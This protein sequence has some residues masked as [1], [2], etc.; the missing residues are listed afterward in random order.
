MGVDSFSSLFLNLFVEEK[1]IL[2]YTN[3]SC[4]SVVGGTCWSSLAQPRTPTHTL[5]FYWVLRGV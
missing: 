1:K 3:P 2:I 5:G 4:G